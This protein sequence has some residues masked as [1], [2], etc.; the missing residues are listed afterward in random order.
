ME[1]IKERAFL[2]L[3][4]NKGLSMVYWKSTGFTTPRSNNLVKEFWVRIPM[5][6]PDL[7]YFSLMTHSFNARSRFKLHRHTVSRNNLLS[8]ADFTVDVVGYNYTQTIALIVHVY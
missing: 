6:A 1:S 7:E 8:F 4:A 3:S 2:D 5:G